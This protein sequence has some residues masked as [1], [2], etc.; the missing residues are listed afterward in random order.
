[1]VEAYVRQDNQYNRV[2]SEIDVFNSEPQYQSLYTL[3]TTFLNNQAR[4]INNFKVAQ[5]IN[6][7]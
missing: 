2:S 6:N 3:D 1:M 4:K 5:K 7:N